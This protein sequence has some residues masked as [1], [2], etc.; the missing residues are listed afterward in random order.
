VNIY[1]RNSERT[2]GAVQIEVSGDGYDLAGIIML[3]PA[4][5][6]GDFRGIYATPDG[7]EADYL[8]NR[9]VLGGRLV[10]VWGTHPRSTADMLQ[11]QDDRVVQFGYDADFDED[12]GKS[13]RGD[14]LWKYRGNYG[15][16][17]SGYTRAIYLRG[18]CGRQQYTG[19]GI[20]Q[21]N[22][23]STC[24]EGTTGRPYLS[25]VTQAK[26]YSSENNRD[27]GVDWMRVV[28]DADRNDRLAVMVNNRSLGLYLNSGYEL[29][30]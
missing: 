20:S 8:Y 27:V 10:S 17:P 24:T 28:L 26:G 3:P 30:L 23:A 13:V 11:Q 22:F 9:S 15:G 12:Y 7:L 16:W 2:P 29:K 6:P 5:Q 21:I 1:A 25:W 18:E 4:R 14:G 19:A